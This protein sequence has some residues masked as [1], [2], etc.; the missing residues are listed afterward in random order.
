MTEK[1]R[2]PGPKPDRL[3]IEGE[4][5]DAIDKAIDKKRPE[6]GWPK[7]EGVERGDGEPEPGESADESGD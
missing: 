4:W 3:K 2:H 5:E 1:R 7:Q 6:K